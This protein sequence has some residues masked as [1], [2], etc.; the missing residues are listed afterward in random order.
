MGRNDFQKKLS[1]LSDEYKK[2]FIGW[3]DYINKTLEAYP[4]ERNIKQQSLE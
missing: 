1:G 2:V 4:Y 3:Y